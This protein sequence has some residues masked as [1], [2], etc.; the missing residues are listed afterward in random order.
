MP[1][2]WANVE[3]AADKN[4]HGDCASEAAFFCRQQVATSG[5]N[6]IQS[7]IVALNSESQ[8]KTIFNMS[9][10]PSDI[11]GKRDRQPSSQNTEYVHFNVRAE[12]DSESDFLRLVVIDW[13]ILFG[14]RSSR[15]SK[16]RLHK[17]SYGAVAE[18]EN[19]AYVTT[20]K[21][22]FSHASS[23]TNLSDF[24]S[25]LCSIPG[26]IQAALSTPA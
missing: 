12:S 3:T 18:D 13:W 16:R 10:N 23:P 22:S 4:V 24:C 8:V 14:L 25:S 17:A 9:S 2:Q 1:N 15:H 20:G 26:M 6:I 11:L 19:S 7:I 5:H 21:C